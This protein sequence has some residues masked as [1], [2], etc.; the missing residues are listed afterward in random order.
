M[1]SHL[2]SSFALAFG[3]IIAAGLPGW[4]VE[5]EPIQLMAVT[6]VVAGSH[7]HF[8]VGASING[9]MIDVLVDTGAST[10]ALSY[11]D[12]QRAGLRPNTL[13]YDVKVNTA[14]GTVEAASVKIRSV[15]I[16]NVKVTDIDGMVL[17]P[18]ALK[19]TLLGMSFLSRLQSFRVE[20]G[21]LILKN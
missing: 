18:G 1:A 20:D 16:D 5:A 11:E 15:K 10:V 13:K 4:T 3:F 12:A 2:G 6:E 14:N 19:G 17:P 8:V 21:K 9:N 7:G